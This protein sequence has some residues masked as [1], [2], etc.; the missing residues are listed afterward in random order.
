MLVYLLL[1]PLILLPGLAVYLFPKELKK[2]Y[3]WVMFILLAL[4]MGLR[5]VTVGADHKTYATQFL[6][7]NRGGASENR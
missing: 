7:L 3:L 4:L 6:A 5:D 2:P 1:P